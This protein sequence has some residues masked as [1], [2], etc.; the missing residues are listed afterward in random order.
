MELVNRYSP[1]MNFLGL[2]DLSGISLTEVQILP[3][4]SKYLARFEQFEEKCC[5]YEEEHHVNVIRLNDGDGV[6]IDGTV[7]VCKG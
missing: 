5:I 1:E 7:H 4:Y 6:F 2:A 3:H